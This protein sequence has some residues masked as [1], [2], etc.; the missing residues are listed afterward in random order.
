MTPEYKVQE[1]SEL[2]ANHSYVVPF[3]DPDLNIFVPVFINP[4]STDDSLSLLVTAS[5]DKAVNRLK[6]IREIVSRKRGTKRG[7]RETRDIEASKDRTKRISDLSEQIRDL[8]G[9]GT[10]GIQLSMGNNDTIA[11]IVVVD[12]PQEQKDWVRFSETIPSIFRDLSEH[13]K[14]LIKIVHDYFQIR[15]EV[16]EGRR[17]DEDIDIFHNK[18]DQ[19]EVDEKVYEGLREVVKFVNSD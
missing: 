8:S 17:P 12:I 2:D 4:R 18:L 5:R 1:Y 14:D 15:M 11:G 16:R 13:N 3:Y 6:A 7:A 10:R 9:K 19:R